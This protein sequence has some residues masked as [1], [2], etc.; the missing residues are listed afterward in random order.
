MKIKV[1]IGTWWR[2]KRK[3][4][5]QDCRAKSEESYEKDNRIYAEKGADASC[6]KLG[7]ARARAKLGNAL[8]FYSFLSIEYGELTV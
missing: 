5:A 8:N 1:C 2:V 7:E 4:R 6:F 3:V